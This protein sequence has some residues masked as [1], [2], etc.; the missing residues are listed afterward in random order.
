MLTKT[1]GA[2]YEDYLAAIRRDA[3]A[4]KVKVADMLANLGDSPTERQ[5]LKYAKGFIIL[6]GSRCFR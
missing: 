6:L 3:I 2:R 1:E 4:R 5:I